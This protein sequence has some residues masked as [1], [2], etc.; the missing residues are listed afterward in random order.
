MAQILAQMTTIVCP[1]WSLWRKRQRMVCRHPWSRLKTSFIQLYGVPRGTRARECKAEVPRF[2]G[3][4]RRWRV[5]VSSCWLSVTMFVMFPFR[6]TLSCCVLFFV[7]LCLASCGHEPFV[8]RIVLECDSRH[9]IKSHCP[10][11]NVSHC[12]ESRARRSGKV[13]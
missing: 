5:C 10:W 13:L 1:S 8:S 9:N 2:E 12:P 6:F 4:D 7:F 3:M 11:T